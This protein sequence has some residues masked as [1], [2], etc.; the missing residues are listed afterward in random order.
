MCTHGKSLQPCPTLCDPRD[1]IPLDFS[2]NKNFQAKIL[3]WVAMPFSRGSCQPRNRTPVSLL[4]RQAGSLP[5][6]SPGKPTYIYMHIHHI[7]MSNPLIY[8][9]THTY[10]SFQ[11]FFNSLYRF[12]FPCE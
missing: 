12:H 6:A 1:C 11:R 10:H 2:V 9:Y 3:E 4:H 8:T 7:Y 5:L